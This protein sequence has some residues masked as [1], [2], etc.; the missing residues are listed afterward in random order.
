MWKDLK[1]ETDF[2]LNN[3]NGGGLGEEQLE[4]IFQ[5]RTVKLER[6]K[7]WN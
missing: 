5:S 6:Y 2:C 7:R 4:G 1:P 3:N